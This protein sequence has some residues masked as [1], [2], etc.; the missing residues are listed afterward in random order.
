M[1]ILNGE[2]KKPIKTVVY[3]AEGIG[4]SEFAS[5]FPDPLFIDTEG[6]TTR[7]NVRRLGPIRDWFDVQTAFDYVE[8]HTTCCKTLVIDTV[9]WTERMMI[10]AMIG[11]DGVNGLEGYGYGKGYQYAMEKFQ[12]EFLERL[13]KI[14]MKCKINILILAHAQMRKFEQPDEMG[15]YDRWELKLTKKNCPIL[16]EWAD[17][18]LFVNY[19]TNII[20][21]DGGMEKKSKA[22][23]KGA[24]VMYTTHHSC[25]DAKNRFGL[26]DELPFPRYTAFKE[27]LAYIYEDTVHTQTNSIPE[28]VQESAPPAQGKEEHT[29]TEAEL[30]IDPNI[31]HALRELMTRDGVSEFEIQNLT[32][33]KGIYDPFVKVADY[34]AD[35][36][37]KALIAK[38]DGFLKAIQKA[39]ASETIPFN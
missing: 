11:K 31:P 18:V 1:E 35:F 37:N 14:W 34:S 39:R 6:S 22:V 20:K 13:D 29:P 23:G 10:D 32:A 38:W 12:K 26:P 9:D 8:N 19:K 25:W 5:Q 7:L 28:K 33:A 17:M 16:K 21:V 30:S 4:K 2:M 3:G 36:I 27:N 24:R 15:A